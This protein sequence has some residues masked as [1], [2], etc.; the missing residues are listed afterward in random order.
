[1]SC[2]LQLEYRAA[3]RAANDASESEEVLPTSFKLEDLIFDLSFKN[4]N[5]P[6]PMKRTINFCMA[7]FFLANRL[8]HVQ[9]GI[10]SFGESSFSWILKVWQMTWTDIVLKMFVTC[11]KN[12]ILVSPVVFVF[13]NIF[14][15]AQIDPRIWGCPYCSIRLGKRK[16]T[17]V[18]KKSCSLDR[19]ADTIYHSELVNERFPVNPPIVFPHSGSLS[20][21]LMHRHQLTN[22][23]WKK[24]SQ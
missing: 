10:G 4:T 11:S 3:K 17:G 22:I 7:Q 15:A 5:T 23:C 2:K 20:R 16:Q 12:V 13:Q 19:R 6:A 8:K 14:C 18:I 21:G 24:P 1:M 9:R